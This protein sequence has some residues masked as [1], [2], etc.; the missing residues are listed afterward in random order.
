MSETQPKKQP[1]K[2][3][4]A[5]VFT[6]RTSL[7]VLLLGLASG[8]PY[9]IIAGTLNAW[10]TD[11]DV[12]MSTIGLLSWVG[13][14]YAFK[15][16]WA[17]ALQSRRTPF[18]FNVGPRRFWMFLFYILI[19]IGLFVI[20]FSDPPNGL[21]TI[22][23]TGV[24]I[25]VCSA[26]FDIVQAAWK[27]ET[28][29]DPEHLDILS[30]IEQFGYRTASFLGGAVALILAD[31]VG[32]QITFLIVTGMMVLSGIGIVLAKPSPAAS[33][34]HTNAAQL[35]LGSHVPI[36]WRNLATLVVL[37]GWGFSFYMIGHFMLLALDNPQTYSSRKFISEQGP[38]I[39]GLTVVL[40]GAVAAVL[41]QADARHKAIG[42]LFS[43]QT[44]G[45]AGVLD[46][47]YQAV[48]E[49][50]VE[51]I[52]RLRWATFLIVALILTYRFTDLI[53]GAFAYPFYMGENFGALGHSLSEVGVASKTFGVLFTIL[54]IG[55]GGL[56]MLRFGRMPI[57]FIGAI[58]AAVTNLLFADLALD[59]SFTDAVLHFSQLD[60]V[61]AFFH[62]DIRMARLITVI[63]A[64]NI[65]VGIASAASVAYLSSIVNKEYA[66]V[67]Y[68]LL[69]SLTF[70]I[71]ILGRGAIG[72]IIETKGFAYAFVL[73]AWMGG[74][75]VIFAGLEW[76]RQ[77]RKAKRAVV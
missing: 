13:L 29:R 60:H 53:W 28:A 3:V 57:L 48:L 5:T 39:I 61:F 72:E 22:A 67:Q 71:G 35:S 75:A 24:L 63:A 33:K 77:S 19:V 32:W 47:M 65:A 34:G 37:V 2:E 51:L 66:A 12:K 4:L 64:E 55:L 15:F 56:A 49:P 16:M 69:V 27:I 68:A 59:A 70:L 36:L 1:L 20:S 40:L 46:I 38:V 17:S 21:K 44:K 11:V 52:G 14:A 6:D 76:V 31:H 26:S 10:F 25:A 41:V 73:C 9:V 74:V 54:G 58:L 30:A 45:G 62:Q 8:L 43:S 23:I 7:A 42:T 18:G 50:M